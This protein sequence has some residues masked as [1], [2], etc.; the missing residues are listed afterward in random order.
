VAAVREA[1]SQK[2]REVA[3]PQL[4]RSTFRDRPAL[5]F[6][7]DVAHP[8]S[9]HLRAIVFQ[10]TV[11]YLSRE[12]VQD[13]TRNC[14]ADFGV[15]CFCIS[16]KAQRKDTQ[17]PRQ[18]NGLY[19]RRARTF[20]FTIQLERKLQR[21]RQQCELQRFEHNERFKHARSA[22]AISRAGATFTLLLPDGRA[23]VVNCESKFKER[24]AGPRG[25]RRSCRIP[26]VDDIQA[27]FHGDNA[28]LEWVVSLDGKKTQSETYKILAILDKS[29]TDQN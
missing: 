18:R 23:A 6:P 17:P 15:R 11:G 22:G 27:E 7:R 29:K 12:E 5:Y 19:I 3:H 2:A 24:M 25:N 4:F 21:W 26:L 20:Q 28:K 9:R 10:W 13:E 8:P 14:G 1:T 16:A